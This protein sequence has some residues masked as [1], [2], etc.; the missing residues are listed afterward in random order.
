ME[1]FLLETK[2]NKSPAKTVRT[3]PFVDCYSNYLEPTLLGKVKLFNSMIWVFK[4]ELPINRQMQK[5]EV[6]QFRNCAKNKAYIEV[7]R[8]SYASRESDFC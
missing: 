6:E 1:Y 5:K 8:K 4:F 3:E 7:F 2:L